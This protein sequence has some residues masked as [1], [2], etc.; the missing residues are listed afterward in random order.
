MPLN[1]NEL[2]SSSLPPDIEMPSG[3]REDVEY[4]FSVTYTDPDAM[5]VA[6]FAKAAG[7]AV[8]KEGRDLSTYPPQLGH[9]GLR[10]LIADQL[11]D[12]RGI[13]VSEDNVFLSSGAGGACQTILDAFIEPGDVVMMD[14][15]CYHGSL[16]MFLKKGAYPIH[17]DMDEDGMLPERLEEEIKKKISED[18]QPKMIYTI[19]VYHN[20]TGSTMSLE[21]RKQV[22]DI[23]NRYGIPIVENESYADFRIDGPP[24]PPAMMGLDEQEGVIYLSAFT[25]LL[26]CG[27]RI[28]F[29]AFPE[30]ARE[31]L[32]KVGFGMSPSHLTSMAVHEYLKDHRD[33]YVSGV[34]N[35][36]REK[37]DAL[38][39]SLG[40]YFPPSCN[41][42]EPSG[43]MMLWV[44]LP[45]GADTWDALDRAVAR[46]VKY[47]PGP[48][49]R[50]DR[51]ARNKLRLTYSHNNPEEIEKGIAILADV[52]EK[53]GFFQG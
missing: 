39:R 34:A 10:Q 52:F 9:L 46:G 4:I 23:S 40:E 25:K 1:F 29:G 24:L 36:L 17:I 6:E 13:D 21:R 50:A 30:N 22:V 12:N 26:G 7:R 5:D 37:R 43:G 51:K 44:E 14:E 11:S 19:P 3:L 31:P 20:P 18:I 41:W 45:E 32:Q 28:G 48:V 49:F 27:L 38:L 8:E 35:S 42:T 47:N 33:K 15:Y 16:N 2:I 53:E